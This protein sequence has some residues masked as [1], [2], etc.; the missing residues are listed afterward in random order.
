MTFDVSDLVDQAS[1]EVGTDLSSHSLEGLELG[2][3]DSYYSGF[4]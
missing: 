1:T 3:F 4:T 2:E